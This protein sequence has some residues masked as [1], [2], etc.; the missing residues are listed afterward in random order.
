MKSDSLDKMRI[1]SS[2]S[3]VKSGIPGKRFIT[4]VGLKAKTSP[5][6]YKKAGYAIRNV[7]KKYL[8]KIIR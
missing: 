2:E 6:K 3:K 8:S 4:S 7:S 5:K 1:T